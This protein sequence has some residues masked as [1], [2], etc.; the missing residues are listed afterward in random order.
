MTKEQLVE[1]LRDWRADHAT[2]LEADE[3]EMVDKVITNVGRRPQA[4]AELDELIS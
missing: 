1:Q 3:L 4:A 2:A